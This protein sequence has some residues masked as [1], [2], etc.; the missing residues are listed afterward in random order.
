MFEKVPVLFFLGLFQKVPR[1]IP[2]GWIKNKMESVQ[3]KKRETRLRALEISACP[4]NTSTKSRVL[5]T[6]SGVPNRS[7]KTHMISMGG[8]F[9]RNMSATE[10]MAR[11]PTQLQVE[12]NWT[13]MFGP[14][15]YPWP[16]FSWNK[17]C[18]RK[19]CLVPVR[20]PCSNASFSPNPGSRDILE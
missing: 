16:I 5:G 2:A 11:K 9:H 15:F 10:T 19:C 18:K 6:Q 13:G 17:P 1:S 8:R 20:E 14:K 12:P 4:Q 7:S 3:L